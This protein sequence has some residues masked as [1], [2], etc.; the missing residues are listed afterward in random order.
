[1]QRLLGAVA[2]GEVAEHA[3]VEEALALG[4]H[5]QVAVVAEL[6]GVVLVVLVLLRGAACLVVGSAVLAGAV[7]ERLLESCA[8]GLARQD[9]VAG[10]QAHAAL[11]H[12]EVAGVQ[13]A[14]LQVLVAQV[15]ARC[16]DDSAGVDLDGAVGA[17]RQDAANL[18]AVH[19]ERGHG[20]GETSV[21]AVVCDGIAPDGEAVLEGRGDEVEA[22]LLAD[23]RGLEAEIRLFEF[24]TDLKQ[25][26]D[27]VLG[28]VNA[29]AHKRG[30]GRPVRV[31]HDMVEDVVL[32]KRGAA[33]LFL[34]HGGADGKGTGDID[35]VRGGDVL[36]LLEHD[37]LGACL[38]GRDG[39]HEACGAQAAYDDVAIDG[40][41]DLGLGGLCGLIGVCAGSA[42]CGEGRGRGSRGHEGTTVHFDAHRKIPFPQRSRRRPPPTFPYR[43][44]RMVRVQRGRRSRGNFSNLRCRGRATQWGRAASRRRSPGR[45]GS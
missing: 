38:G 31:V 22:T 11:G 4:V 43:S 28:L 30:V 24:V 8:Y 1:M 45:R 35:A 10:A 16:D 17:L 13:E 40:L 39:R 19:D 37:D 18:V 41:D 27:G 29:A 3:L 2:H 5:K 9:A 7:A 34:Q 33:F 44:K 14:L 6:E 26:G 15:A 32:G 36:A 23:E 12:V 20:R 25:V 21:D 42:R